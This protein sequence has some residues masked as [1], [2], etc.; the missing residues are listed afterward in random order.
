MES[1]ERWPLAGRWHRRLQVGWKGLQ[2][3]K[4]TNSSFGCILWQVVVEPH[5]QEALASHPL[6]ERLASFD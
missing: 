6:Q 2:S 4:D 3:T 5:D 1:H